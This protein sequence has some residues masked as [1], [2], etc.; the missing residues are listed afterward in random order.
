[1]NIHEYQ[2]KQILKRFQV[3]VP[4]GRLLEEGADIEARA[5]KLAQDLAKEVGNAVWVVKAQ[6]H[7]GG[8]GKAGGVKVCKD[9]ASVK[10]AAK[11]IMGKTLVTPQTGAQGKK[12]H[13]IWI[14]EGSAI[15]K[16]FYF[17]ILLDR[18][19]SQ[20]IMMASTEGGM[21]IEEV[22]ATHPEKISRV[23]VDPTTGYLP[24]HG[25]RLA[26]ALGLTPEQ[27]KEAVGF[28]GNLYRCYMEMDCA[29]LELNPLILTQQGHLAALDAKFN[30]DDNA[31][32]RHADVVA[33]RD[34][35]EENAQDVEASKFD[36]AYIA[37]EGNIGCLV[38][39]AGLAMATMDIIKLHG[40][41]PANFLDVGGGA[42]KEKVT[43]A[44]KII[45]KDP[46]VKAILVNIFG[47]IM[48]CDVIAEGVIAAARELALNVP[49]VVRLEGTN[50]D[51][52]KK[53]LAESGLRITP[54]DNLADAA[55]KVVAAARN[56]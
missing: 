25:R 51:L 12:V 20:V 34:I 3:R 14:E 6:I 7:A 50:V 43:H 47:G 1:M 29:L 26:K 40:G 13:K 8:R 55:K 17:S 52:G 4:E 48:K 27:T 10:A 24:F 32:Y 35:L 42:S 37:L 28:F 53:I 23:A 16:E 31:L 21:D 39:G 9:I 38:N 22:A 46:N 41:E 44:F 56:G 19:I 2:G 33:M 54:A 5:E 15:A 45:L 11:D 36:L 30:F 18:A 49:L